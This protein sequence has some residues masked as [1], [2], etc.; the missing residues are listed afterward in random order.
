[1]EQLHNVKAWVLTATGVLCSVVLESLGGY[2]DF[3]KTLIVFMVIDIFTG[4]LVAAVFKASKKTESGR[5]ASAAGF[6]GLL[7]KGC[8]MLMILIAVL[9][10][11]LMHTQGL[12]R[13][14]VIIAFVLNELI[15][16][17]ENMGLMGV[18]LPDALTNALDLLS[19]D[20]RNRS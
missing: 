6:R 3:L 11:D 18:K 14:A 17:L 12:T 5:L 4:W 7:K 16:I 15:S 20:H 19:K 13:D 1:M 9:L 2:D 8:M 10:D